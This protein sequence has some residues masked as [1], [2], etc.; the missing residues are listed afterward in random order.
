MVLAPARGGQADEQ[1]PR[2][3]RASTPPA[4]ALKGFGRRL[5]PR[6]DVAC[7]LLDARMAFGRRDLGRAR[8]SWVERR[9]QLGDR[10]KDSLD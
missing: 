5:H 7:P 3:S 10:V 1:P 6:P 8:F 9:V 4:P 2:P